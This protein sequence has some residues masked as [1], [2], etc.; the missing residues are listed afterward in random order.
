MPD[1]A[2]SEDA[3]ELV[4][5][6]TEALS[7]NMSRVIDLF[8]EWDDDGD[9][10]VSRRGERPL[11]TLLPSPVLGLSGPHSLTHLPILS[12]LIY[13]VPPRAANAGL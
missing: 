8:K 6:L 1:V 11:S 4:E 9:G 12:H 3:S 13:R 7:A 2:G 5:H 10:Q